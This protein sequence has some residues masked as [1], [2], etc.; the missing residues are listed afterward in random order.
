MTP[1]ARHA[2]AIEILG[3]LLA[4]E[5]VEKTLSNWGRRNRYAGS[6]DRAAI[7]DIVFSCLRCLRSTAAMGGGKTGRGMVLGYLRGQGVD[8]FT[9]FTGENYAPSALQDT[10]LSLVV[11]LESLPNAVQLDCPD[12]AEPCLRANLGDGFEDVMRLNQSRAPLFLRVNRR[13]S[14]RQ[15]VIKML[16]EQGITAIANGLSPTALEV[17]EHPRRVAQCAAYQSGIVEIQDAASQAVVEDLPIKDGQKIL[18]YC[19]GGGGKSLAMADRGAVEI[20]AHDSNPARMRDLVKR[21]N[22]AGVRI[23]TAEG[24]TAGQ[25]A[26]FDLVLVDAPCSGSGTW[27][28]NPAAKWN[29]TKAK[30]LEYCADQAKILDHAARFVAAG[31]CLAYVTCSIFDQENGGQITEFLRR[32]PDWRLQNSRQLS[33]LDGGDGMYMANL[34]TR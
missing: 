14:D 21:A 23:D 31:G 1:P 25:M 8:P 20:L 16:A 18:D 13:K 30:L 19:A 4:G 24:L 29:L 5:A 32:H 6:G 26:S 10:E 2:A 22:R 33:P 7:R 11:D 28:R 34:L 15:G 27:R 17:T 3:Q 12:W 9:I